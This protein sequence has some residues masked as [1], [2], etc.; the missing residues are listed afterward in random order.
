MVITT[1]EN[2]AR[3]QEDMIAVRSNLLT[4]NKSLSDLAELK[5]L[6]EKM[7]RNR[8]GEPLERGDNYAPEEMEDTLGGS[9]KMHQKEDSEELLLAMRRFEIPAFNGTGDNYLSEEMEDTLGGSHKIHQKE[10]SEELLLAMRR[11]EIPAFDGT[12]PVG[13]LGKAEQ[14]F[15]QRWEGLILSSPVEFGADLIRSAIESHDAK[16]IDARNSDWESNPIIF[17]FK[18]AGVNCVIVGSSPRFKVYGMDFGWGRPESVR[19]GLNN[20]FDGRVYLYPGKDGGRSI[21]FMDKVKKIGA[22]LVKQVAKATNEMAGDGPTCATVLTQAIFAEGCKLVAAGMNAMDLRRGISTAVDAVVTNLKRRA[23]IISTSEEIAQV[24]TIS[25]NG[26]RE[27]ALKG[28]KMSG[29]FSR[30]VYVGNLPADIRES[31]VEDL[32]YMYGCILDIELKIPPRTPCYCFVEFENAW[33]AED[34]IRGRGDYN[35]DGCRLRVELAHGGRGSSSSNERHSGHGHGADG[36]RYGIPRHSDYRVVVRGFPSSAS[37]QDLKDHMRKAGDLFLLKFYHDSEGAYGL[38]DYTNYEDMK[39]AIRKLDDKEFK[40]PWTRT[41]ISPYFVTNQKNQKWKDVTAFTGQF[42]ESRLGDKAASKDGGIV[43]RK[44][45]KG[46][47][48]LGHGK[49]GSP[50]DQEQAG[51]P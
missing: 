26:E 4:V 37:W 19:S 27:I 40:N 47:D 42:P 16:A 23:R 43:M 49:R 14:Y 45:I 28:L 48:Q 5:T 35:F 3:L 34:A 11:F 38:V 51:P 18:D 15:G 25:A 44:T 33:D 24:G 8:G 12:D 46:Q 31:E 10:D 32:F 50:M 6:V 22:S 1:Q 21:E 20:K 2:V 39:H 7:L 29:R 9:H 17:Q 13:R 30:L 41:Y 36:G